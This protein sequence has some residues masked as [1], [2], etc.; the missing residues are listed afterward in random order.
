MKKRI[1]IIIITI[2][3]VVIGALVIIRLFPKTL[4]LEL[5]AN[6]TT[7]YSWSYSLSQE[8]I[9]KFVKDEY[10]SSK[11]DSK[12]TGVGGKQ[13]YEIKGLKEGEVTITFKYSRSWETDI[14]PIETKTITLIVE[15]NLKVKEK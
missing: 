6:A 15:K 13:V 12:L 5:E 4:K 10:V 14:E 11:N 1:F 3:L 8:N 9:V 7:G 2:L